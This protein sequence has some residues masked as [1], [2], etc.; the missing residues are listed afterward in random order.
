MS[1]DDSD[2]RFFHLGIL[3][4][5]PRRVA[6][7]RRVI[8][9]NGLILLCGWLTVFQVEPC[10][11]QWI[12]KQDLVSPLVDGEP[13]DLL[14]LNKDGDNAYLKIVPQLNPPQRPFPAKGS[15]VFEYADGSS[16]LLQVPYSSIE[17]YKTFN[18]LLI[19]E[20]NGW[21]ENNDYPKAFRNLLY[22][23]DHGGKNDAQLVQSLRSCLFLDGADNF[24]AGR[25]ELALSIYEDI[26]RR[27]PNFVVAGI[28][29][30]LIEIVMLCYDGMIQKQFEAADYLKVQLKLASVKEKYGDDAAALINK[31]EQRFLAKADELMQQSREFAKQGNGR[32]AHLASRQAE[33]MAPGREAVKQLQEEI[34]K[35]FPLIVVGVSQSGADADPRR[36]EDWGARRTGRLTQRTMVEFTGLTDEGGKY[37]FLNGNLYRAD[38]IGLQYI[39][40]L[41][42]ER[43][44][45]GI[46]PTTAFEVSTRLLNNA[47]PDSEEFDIALGKVI[48]RVAI[49]GENRVE[50][51][52]RTPYVRPEALMN[53][54]YDRPTADSPRV[55]NGKYIQTLQ[56]GDLTTF[57]LNPLYEPVE[58]RQHPVIVEQLYRSASEAVD[59]LIKG[60][61]DVVDRIP[62]ADV[63]RAKQCAGDSCAAVYFADGSHV[64]PKDP[65]RIEG[66][67]KFSQWTFDRDQPRF[68]CR[69]CDLRWPGNQRLRG[70]QWSV[71]NRN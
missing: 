5:A 39:L 71:S 28:D 60:N 50:V 56:Q 7:A 8:L 38:E 11:G 12:E 45:F 1:T 51:T 47:D 46:P 70:D 67:F 3:S 26:Y 23:Y 32:Q 65:G 62:A 48:D 54:P 35:Q 37:S 66:Q 21:L 36:I 29:N 16:D 52:L 59:E 18:E 64:D 41:D 53:I 14:K 20:A 40:E 13:F 10:S 25:Y 69:E 9:S 15:F 31:W 44:E 68:D 42:P 55:Q 19:E 2:Y 30:S 63:R 27:D 49:E 17:F 61:I 58:G 43:N 34:L 24:K 22:V 6:L 33:Q 57:E 4:T